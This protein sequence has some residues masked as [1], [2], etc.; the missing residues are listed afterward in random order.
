MQQRLQQ[1]GLL[2]LLLL[3]IHAAAPLLALPEQRELQRQEAK[4]WRRVVDVAKRSAKS[5]ARHFLEERK[6]VRSCQGRPALLTVPAAAAPN[7][8]H[9]TPQEL[10]VPVEIDVF[11]IGF[12]GDGAYGYQLQPSRLL[13]ML[14]SSLSFYCPRV[15]DTEEDLGVC[16]SVNFQ[17]MGGSDLPQVRG[18]SSI[19]ELHTPSDL[20]TL[21]YTAPC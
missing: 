1:R 21:Q 5:A 14:S 3:A 18:G 12:D 10:Q 9:L 13:Q 17:V 16:F 15:W 11:L 4:K 19:R 7:H 6:Q 8:Q 2:C 20:R